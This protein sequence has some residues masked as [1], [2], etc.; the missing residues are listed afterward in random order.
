MGFTSYNVKVKAVTYNNHIILEN[1]PKDVESS[2]R[3]LLSFKDKSKQYELRR[4]QRNPWGRNSNKVQQLKADMDK[5]L[6]TRVGNKFVLPPG[7]HYLLKDLH[8]IQIEDHRAETG[9]KCSFP[10][11]SKPN[12]LRPYQE[13]ALTLV[14]TNMRGIINLATGLGKTRLA[15]SMVRE[16]ETKTLIVVPSESIAKQFESQLKKAFGA[17]KVGYY[18]G[19]RKKICDI[20]VGIAASVN[21]NVV[22]FS[23][24]DLGLIIFDETHHIS[25]DTFFSIAEG[26]GNVGRLYGLTATDYRSDG[27]DLMINAACG[28]VLISRSIAWGIEQGFLAKPH[29]V[30]REVNT[31]G[32]DYKDD[33]LKSYKTHV[34][35]S[36]EMNE[37]I[38]S[39]AV[40]FIKRGK[41]TLI[42][43]DE[44]AHGKYLADQL[45]LDF[46]TG[47][48]KNSQTYVDNF[49]S[50]K[51]NGLVAT[52]SKLGE[53]TD[54]PKVEVI[55]MVNFVA[56][57]G[58][59]IQCIGRGLRIYPGKKACMILDYIPMGS[60]MMKRHALQRVSYYKEI[61]DNVKVVK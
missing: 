44:V 43:V 8:G 24:A 21:N 45:G 25:A 48:D 52:D 59:V 49:N 36:K 40:G 5:C 29:F 3:Q 55:M 60:T 4:L 37:R 28:N 50:G 15:L 16:L 26:L 22:A 41:A 20:T 23:K 10:W 9:K 57:K 31:M 18:G 47:V 54:I 53:G 32:T 34:L 7:F 51:I 38:L 12:E 11:L 19:G 6:L 13:E 42:L 46:A 61:T 14:K 17:D 56:S 35:N 30:V 39:D 33:K 58:P 2:L 27:K 1:I